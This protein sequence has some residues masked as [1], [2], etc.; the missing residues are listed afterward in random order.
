LLSGNNSIRRDPSWNWAD[1]E[2]I[3]RE[4]GFENYKE[5]NNVLL[6]RVNLDTPLDERD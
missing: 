6:E 1:L 4:T 3:A 5:I 2:K